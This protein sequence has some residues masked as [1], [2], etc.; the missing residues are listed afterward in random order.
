MRAAG[1]AR[2]MCSRASR[3]SNNTQLQIGS[4][5]LPRSA[6]RCLPSRTHIQRTHIHTRHGENCHRH[7]DR[8][9]NWHLG[10]REGLKGQVLI[11]RGRLLTL[12]EDFHCFPLLLSAL[13]HFG[14]VYVCVHAGFWFWTSGITR[15]FH[16]VL[17]TVVYS[18]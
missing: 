10:Q 17:F 5:V 3:S 13:T 15:V 9:S 7:S 16:I 8:P 12:A 2:R 1:E 14:G 4:G 11:G 6:F 18:I